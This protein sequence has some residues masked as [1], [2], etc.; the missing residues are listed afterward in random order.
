M[1]SNR[2]Y[3]KFLYRFW[4]FVSAT[5]EAQ[6]FAS[7]PRSMHFQKFRETDWGLALIRVVFNSCPPIGGLAASRGL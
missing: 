5:G 3:L 1:P 6:P 2:P 4:K 7:Y